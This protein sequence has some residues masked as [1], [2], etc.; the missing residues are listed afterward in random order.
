MQDW[1]RVVAVFVQG[2]MWQFRDFPFTVRAGRLRMRDEAHLK[3]LVGRH[4]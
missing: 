3:P 4:L 1:A 2:A